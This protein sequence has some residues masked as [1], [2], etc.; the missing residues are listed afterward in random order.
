MLST[1]IYLVVIALIFGAA[2]LAA[3]RSARL[4]GGSSRWIWATAL[5]CTAVAAQITPPESS[6]PH[7]ITLPASVLDQYVGFYRFG[8]NA[9]MSVKRDGSHLITQM[10]AQGPVEIFPESRTEFFAKIVKAQI[11]FVQDGQGETTS[12]VVHQNGHDVPGQRTDAGTAAQINANVTAKYRSQTPNPG[13]EAA[14]R[15]LIEGLQYRADAYDVRQQNGVTHWVISLDASGKVAGAFVT[16]GPGPSVARRGRRRCG[17]RGG[18]P[19]AG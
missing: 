4:A 3:E 17:P 5:A 9:V 14:L 13:S 6:A 11:T 12:L 19:R 1:M 16:P 7:A 18:V 8:E 2:G 10:T 15:H